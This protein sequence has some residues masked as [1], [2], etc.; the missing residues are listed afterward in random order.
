MA[1]PTLT[2]ERLHA[3]AKLYEQGLVSDLM[4]RTL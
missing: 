2:A 4:E 3:L 1:T